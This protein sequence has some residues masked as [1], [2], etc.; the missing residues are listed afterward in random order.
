MRLEDGIRIFSQND[1]QSWKT[2]QN[3]SPLSHQ[4]IPEK[5][6]E[7][8][9]KNRYTLP[10]PWEKKP[11]VPSGW[12]RGSMR[13]DKRWEMWKPNL[14]PF[15]PRWEKKDNHIACHGCFCWGSFFS[16]EFVV[17]FEVSPRAEGGRVI[18]R[19]C[20]HSLR[21]E[22]LSVPSTRFKFGCVS[23]EC[24]LRINQEQLAQA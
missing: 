9:R 23:Q 12:K 20:A 14:I 4:Q 3:E 1:F 2:Q 16:V 7:Y 15:D 8:Q 5:K 19:A 6:S 13:S 21:K 11:S 24:N 10:H 18:N 17:V 22:K